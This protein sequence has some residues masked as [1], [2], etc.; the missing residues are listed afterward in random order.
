MDDPIKT[1]QQTNWPS[2]NRKSVHE[3]RNNNQINQT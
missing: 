2:I 3:T 1:L